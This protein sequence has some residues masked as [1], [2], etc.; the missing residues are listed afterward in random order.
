MNRGRSRSILRL[1]RE[2]TATEPIT[3]ADYMRM[4]LYEPSVG[5]YTAAY[6]SAAGLD[7]TTSPEISPLF[8]VL[9]AKRMLDVWDSTG[10]PDTFYVLELGA[11]TPALAAPLL[12]AMCGID[13]AT[14]VVKRWL[15]AT[16]QAM[17][18]AREPRLAAPGERDFSK[19]RD[20]LGPFAD[21]M[22]LYLILEALGMGMVSATSRPRSL[23]Y[24]AVDPLFASSSRS[25]SPL[26][27][28]DTRDSET[29]VA[30]AGAHGLEAR[31]IGVGSLAAASVELT[32]LGATH[33]AVIANE[34]L[35]NQPAHLLL[36]SSRKPHTELYV[37]VGDKGLAF[38]PGPLSKRA[39]EGLESGVRSSEY[40][41]AYLP[42][43]IR[44]RICEALRTDPTELPPDEV[45]L[46]CSPNQIG[47]LSEAAR[48]KG[49]H[50]LLFFDMPDAAFSHTPVKTFFGHQ[51]GDDPLRSPGEADITVPVHWEIAASTLEEAGFATRRTTQTDWVER[52]GIAEVR[53]ALST[54]WSTGLPLEDTEEHAAKTRRAS[55]S[56]KSTKSDRPRRGASYSEAIGDGIEDA[57]RIDPSRAQGR[58][59]PTFASS[60]RHEG[61]VALR[62]DPLR[63]LKLRSLW[64]QAGALSDPTGLGGFTVLDA[65]K[66]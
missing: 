54:S 16:S 17:E 40:S 43:G 15:A 25:S 6:R 20:F 19:K 13:A 24:A 59:A 60:P 62:S 56:D 26:C 36:A 48:T 28:S 37:S 23:V 39:A 21:T 2:R 63:Y 42:A 31:W 35:D 64:V 65:V 12:A 10:R 7:Y 51:Q 11:R 61:A 29:S 45:V 3:F 22:V 41:L 52:L 50:A 33:G 47:L 34:V 9:I 30:E 27:P 14:R 58:R 8:G 66:K 4:V 32:A 18:P 5:Y 44:T 38:V 1:L 46:V 57:N 53:R 55:S 49:C